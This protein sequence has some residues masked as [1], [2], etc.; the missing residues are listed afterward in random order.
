MRKR[1]GL[2][3]NCD[4]IHEYEETVVESVP[5]VRGVSPGKLNFEDI[6]DVIDNDRNF[7]LF[8]LFLSGF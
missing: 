8:L 3:K 7:K 2:L 5:K 4:T 6:K 1:I